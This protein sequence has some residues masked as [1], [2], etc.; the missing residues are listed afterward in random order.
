[1]RRE[2]CDGAF[3]YE[4]DGSYEIFRYARTFARGQTVT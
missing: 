1:M 3:M 4:N 2:S